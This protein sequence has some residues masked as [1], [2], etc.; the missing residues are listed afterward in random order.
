VCGGLLR[1]A[2]PPLDVVEVQE[3]PLLRFRA[4]GSILSCVF[5]CGLLPGP[6]AIMLCLALEYIF[7]AEKIA[8]LPSQTG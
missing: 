6:K 2:D 7:F 3:P 4:L 5:E 1:V 8:K